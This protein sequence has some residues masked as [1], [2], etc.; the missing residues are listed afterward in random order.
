[1]IPL[2]PSGA[3]RESTFV[4]AISLAD[5]ELADWASS[6]ARAKLS[7]VLWVPVGSSPG[8]GGER[9]FGEPVFWRPTAEQERVLRD[10]FEELMGLSGIGRLEAL[11]AHAGMALQVRPKAASGRSRTV[12]FGA[13]GERIATVPRGFYLRARFTAA[14]LRDA[15]ARPPR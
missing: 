1:T 13:E 2:G 8:A 12:A 11:S 15:A 4:C 10:D 6:R 9:R 3:P 7:H 5:A 14:L